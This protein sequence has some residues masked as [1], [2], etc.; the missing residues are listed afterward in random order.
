M[1]N[2][3]AAAIAYARLGWH[4]FPLAKG[5]K[6][7]AIKGGRGVHDATVDEK[8]IG[9]WAEKFSGAN[10]GIACGKVSGIVVIDIDP[11]N[12]ADATMARLSS[13]GYTFPECPCVQ[14]TSNGRHLYFRWDERIANSKNRLGPGIDV[15]STGGYVVAPPSKINNGGSYRWLTRPDHLP[16]LPV[17]AATMLAPAPR[18]IQN[19]PVFQS[20]APSAE[21]FQRLIKF[22]GQSAAGDR[23]N[24]LY[25]VSCRAVEL[26]K[27][28]QVSQDGA[29]NQI[30]AQAVAIGLPHREAVAT[31][32]SAFFVGPRD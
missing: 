20:S 18:P 21:A 12:G 9:A 8:K 1:I 14:T 22:L 10:L 15:K 6:V 28:H 19:Q 11:R 23:N 25:W 2:F 24:R 29:I 32:R 5:T 26:V 30:L 31:I 27:S 3:K 4:V 13:R 7:P 17:W 16:R